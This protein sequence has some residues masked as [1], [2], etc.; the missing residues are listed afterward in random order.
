ML[1]EALQKARE[2]EAK[3]ETYIATE[4][5]PG[6]H[7][8]PRVGWM[9]DPNGFSVYQGQY[10][11]F[12]QYHPYSTQWG[13]MH[14][15]HAVSDDL[16]HWRYLPAAIAPDQCYDQG[17]C[18]PVPPWSFP[19]GGNCCSIRACGGWCGKTAPCRISKP[20]V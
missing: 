12:Y 11:L 9:N 7:L 20:N 4:E 3:F 16:L 5:R 1:T 18:F 8:T 19:M 17:G 10:H 13:P 2:Y 6:F 14:W 15:G